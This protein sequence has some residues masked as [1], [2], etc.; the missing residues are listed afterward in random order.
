VIVTPSALRNLARLR[1]F[2][3]PK[4]PL[5]AQRAAAAIAKAIVLLEQHPQIGKVVEETNGKIRDLP[6]PFGQ[7]GYIARYAYDGEQVEIL[8]IRHMR[9]AGF[10]PFS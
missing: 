10:L 4:N 7:S 5:A 2:L 3:R 8:A 6:I 1:D 9:E